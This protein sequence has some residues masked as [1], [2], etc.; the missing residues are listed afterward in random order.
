MRVVAFVFVL[1]AGWSETTEAKSFE[2]EFNAKIYGNFYHFAATPNSL[3][4]YGKIEA[5]AALDFRK[6]LRF[7]DIEDLVLMSFGGL[8]AEG[9]QISGIVHDRGINTLIPRRDVFMEPAE[10]ASACSFIYFAGKKRAALGDLGIHQFYHKDGEIPNSDVQKTAALIIGTLRSYGVPSWVFERMFETQGMYYLTR[11]ELDTIDKTNWEIWKPK[12]NDAL[13]L[14]AKLFQFH[15]PDADLPEEILA[16]T[17]DLHLKKSAKEEVDLDATLNQ[18]YDGHTTNSKI[19]VSLPPSNNSEF[20]GIW[21]NE[22]VKTIAS[23]IKPDANSSAG[24]IILE[25]VLSSEGTLG[26]LNLVGS[27][28]DEESAQ[29][30]LNVLQEIK[31]PKAPAT[32]GAYADRYA[33]VLPLLISRNDRN[34]Y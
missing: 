24:Q 17:Q 5:G 26:E 2:E 28:L 21:Y 12:E 31:Y 14:F 23:G 10:C 4:L 29:I 33:F 15:E 7:H 22:I 1:L 20:E 8:V 11:A 25:L 16:L 13:R 34:G 30:W 18:S 3:Y 32:R 27:T 19:R 9:L 6:A